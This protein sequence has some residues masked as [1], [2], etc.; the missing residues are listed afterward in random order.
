MHPVHD[1]RSIGELFSE[2]AR[3][4]S[5]L[6]RQEVALA[7]TEMSQKATGLGK[8]GAFIGAGAALAYAAL[9]AVLG[10]VALLLGEVMPLWFAT[11]LVAAIAGGVGF[12]LIQK[13]IKT[14]KQIDLKPEETIQTLKEDKQ[15]ARHQMA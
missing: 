14:L 9:L 7:K 13:G 12:F 3:E 5:A 4:T 8:Q 6:V 15:W 2:L 1:Q 10:A 11:L